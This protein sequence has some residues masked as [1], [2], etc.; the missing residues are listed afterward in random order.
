MKHW[1]P[2]NNRSQRR[3]RIVTVKAVPNE[4]SLGELA[5]EIQVIINKTDIPTGVL[6]DIG[7]A[8]KDQQE[9]FMD[10]GLLM[11]ISLILVYIVM[12]SQFESFKIP[13]IIMFSIPFSFSGVVIALWL[14][15]TNLSVI[16]ALGAVLLIGIVVKNAIVLVDYINLM[17]DRGYELIEA[18]AISGKSRL[19]PVLMTA[20]TTGLGMLPLA[21]S[22]GE[23]SE[24]WTPMGIA[25]I[26]G[27][28]FS[29]FLT[30]IVIP[31][32]Y[33][34]LERPGGRKRNKIAHQKNY[35]FMD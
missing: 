15:G 14:T 11:L 32:A 20:L 17:R 1:L 26:G 35:E 25:V 18:I 10:L 6:V 27:L 30:L 21:L 7:G 23:G 28:L 3:E 12:A 5:K 31:I 33:A 19:R 13:L 16:A 2:P 34:I 22:S 24:I 8:Y 9:S 4:T 29:T